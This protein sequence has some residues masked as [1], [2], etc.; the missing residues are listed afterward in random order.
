MATPRTTLLSPAHAGNTDEAN[1]DDSLYEDSENTDD[2]DENEDKDVNGNEN[3]VEVYEIEIQDLQ[4]DICANGLCFHDVD[5]S[6]DEDDAAHAA[7][8]NDEDDDDDD[9]PEP[10][11]DSSSDYEDISILHVCN[12]L[13]A[14]ARLSPS[15]LLSQPSDPANKR[16]PFSH[17]RSERLSQKAVPEIV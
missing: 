2:D 7:G 5:N 1:D 11:N 4:D 12:P 14:F 17:S 9:H 10:D 16:R 13:L 3:E 6:E 15:L 8:D